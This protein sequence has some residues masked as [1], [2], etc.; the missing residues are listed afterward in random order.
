LDPIVEIVQDTEST[1]FEWEGG[2]E[3]IDTQALATQGIATGL[4]TVLGSQNETV[5]PAEIATQIERDPSTQVMIG[6]RVA[7]NLAV[8]FG[9]NLTDVQDRT[10]MLQAWG[11]PGLPGF[12]AQ[13][14]QETI[15]D[16]F[17]IN[18]QKQFKWGGGAVGDD[19]PEIGRLRL[20]G[21]W[22]ISKRSLRKATRLRRDQPFDPFLLFVGAV[23]LERALAEEGYQRA[24]VSSSLT[25]PE[26]NPTLVFACD[27]GPRQ[28]VD[29]LGDLPPKKV[30]RQVTALYRSSPLESSAFEDM[31]ELVKFHFST[32][33]YPKATVDVTRRDDAVAVEVEKRNRLALSGPV[34]EG[35][36]IEAARDITVQLGS[37]VVLARAFENPDRLA[38]RVE[39]L[40]AVEGYVDARVNRVWIDEVSDSSAVIRV[41]VLAGDRALIGEVSLV[42]SDPLGL[43]TADKFAIRPEMALD[44]TEIDA[45]IRRLRRL[46]LAA[47]YREVT[48]RSSVELDEHAQWVVDLQLNPG[49][50]RTVSSISLDGGRGLNK[51]LLRRGLALEEG[52]VLTDAAMDRSASQIANFAPVERVD[53][54][55]YDRGQSMVDV[56]VEVQPKRR[57]TAYVGGGLSTERGAQINFGLRDDNLFARGVSA[58]LRG[59]WDQTNRRLFTIFS[60]PPAPGSRWTLISTLGYGVGDAPD[61]PDILQQDEILASIEAQYAL[62]G[63]VALGTYYRWTDIRTY[64]KQPDDFFPLD[65]RVR[66][67]L[68]GFRTLLD[69]YDNLFDPKKGFGLTSDIGWSAEALGSD[70]EYVNWLTNFGFAIT[71]FRRSTW[72]QT[73]RFGVAEPF[74]GT[75]LTRDARYFAGGQGS[76]RGFD[77]N[78]VGPVTFGFEGSL[79]PAGGGALFILHEEIRLPMWNQ[80]R[81]AVFADIG[82]VWENWGEADLDLSIGVGIGVRWSTPVG[83]LWADVAWPV[84]NVGISS[85]TPK[86]YLGI[87]RPF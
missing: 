1:L 22:P 19:R 44:R 5:Q 82:Q 73:A 78:S 63:R 76:M 34:V 46:Y 32:R 68:L 66:T 55:T 2:G 15:I 40:L 84:A 24:R 47:G 12:V 52:D 48:A 23:R 79:V 39:R 35:V 42:G 31:R 33:G 9:T 17:G 11:F 3:E 83:L 50:R 85:S 58:E 14:Y 28:E 43:M 49:P 30:R 54:R 77:R 18:A 72:L 75:R 7:R 56:E 37:P 16:N 41:D 74:G 71:P 70:F 8:F 62:T 60:M 25:G 4:N 87:G 20:E 64:E 13:V 53:I 27:P 61:E 6:Q 51:R 26:R 10:T 67:G 80:L 59:S 86:F 69:R 65:V 36:P 29:F 81:A 45:E 21:E 57:W 38:L